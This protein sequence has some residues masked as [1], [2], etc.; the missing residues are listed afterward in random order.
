MVG[1]IGKDVVDHGDILDL[2]DTQ[3]PGTAVG[4]NVIAEGDIGHVVIIGGFAHEP[5]VEIV[6]DIAV[7]GDMMSEFAVVVEG[8]ETIDVRIAD[9]VEQCAVEEVVADEVVIAKEAGIIA[10]AVAVLVQALDLVTFHQ[11]I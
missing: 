11:P 9:F 3:P 4:E 10:I 8:L 7:D 2:V 1:N 6:T 5:L